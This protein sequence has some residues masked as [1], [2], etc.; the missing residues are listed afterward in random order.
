M[1]KI[2]SLS[3][4]T[5]LIHD[6]E[7]NHGRRPN[8]IF[9]GMSDM[10]SVFNDIDAL[11]KCDES[12]FFKSETTPNQGQLCGIPYSVIGESGIIFL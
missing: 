12:W 11:I 5:I 10:L 3:E 2:M 7:K 9:I 8:F 1:I 6:F 4:L